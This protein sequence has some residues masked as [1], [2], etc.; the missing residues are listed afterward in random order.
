MTNCNVKRN[1]KKIIILRYHTELTCIFI[2]VLYERCMSDCAMVL[3]YLLSCLLA[4]CLLMLH[5]MFTSLKHDITYP[6]ALFLS[7]ARIS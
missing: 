2:G 5:A 3:R 7:V 1:L 4:H 6:L